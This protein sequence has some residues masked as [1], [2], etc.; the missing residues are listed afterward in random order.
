MTIP[1]KPRH[2]FPGEEARRDALNRLRD[3]ARE[4]DPDAARVL[5]SDYRM[6]QWVCED[7]EDYKPAEGN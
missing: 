5:W 2:K 3:R 7:I 1:K 6:R 4:G